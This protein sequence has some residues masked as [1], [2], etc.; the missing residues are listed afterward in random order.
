MNTNVTIARKTVKIKP[1]VFDRAMLDAE[2]RSQSQP[3]LIT[4]LPKKQKSK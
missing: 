1:L 4:I 2:R 3:K